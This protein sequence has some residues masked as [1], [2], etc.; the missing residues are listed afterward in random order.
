MAVL[1]G[2]DTGGTFTDAVLV[3]E[4]ADG[5]TVVLATAK[6]PTTHGDL[7]IGVEE[8]LRSVVNDAP[9]IEP[10]DISLVSLSTTL[11]TNALVEGH[12]EPIGLIAAAS[13]Y[14]PRSGWRFRRS[15]WRWPTR[16]EWRMWP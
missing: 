10:G 14:G 11:A 16:R 9:D 13:C 1:L 15:H 3:R 12:G 5:G 2:I 6:S 8:A 4:A 7:E